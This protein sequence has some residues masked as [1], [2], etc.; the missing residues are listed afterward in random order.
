MEPEMQVRGG[1]SGGVP[2]AGGTRRVAALLACGLALAGCTASGSGG[3]PSSTE[4]ASPAARWVQAYHDALRQGPINVRP[5]YATDAVLDPTALGMSVA[6]GPED[7]VRAI[8]SAFPVVVDGAGNGRQWLYASADGLVESSDVLDAAESD[9]R[10][11][12]SVSHFGAD[13]VD[14][15]A[16]ALAELSW[17]DEHP[18]DPRI[19]AVHELAQ[20]YVAAWSSGSIDSA[21]A[22][23]APDAT[24]SDSLLGVRAAT[25]AD[26]AALA[27]AAPTAGGLPAI[28]LAQLP[29]YGGP[30]V[31]VLADTDPH[32]AQPMSAMVLLLDSTEAAACPGSLA[33]VAQLDE[34]GRIIEEARYHGLDDLRRCVPGAGPAEPSGSAGPAGSSASAVP[35]QPAAAA[36]P[37]WWDELTIPAPVA[38]EQTGTVRIGE[39]DVPVF[40]ATPGMADLVAWGAG[41]Y[42]A[43]GLPIP[44]VTEV[45]FYPPTVDLCQG[46]SGLA[47][48][49]SLSLCFD[50]RMSCASEDCRQWNPA[51]RKILLHE[52]G[53]A[54]MSDNLERSTIDR[55]TAQSGLP[56]WASSAQWEQ[57]AVELAASTLSWGLMDEPSAI[58]PRFGPRSCAELAALFRTLTGATAPAAATCADTE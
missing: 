57:R 25:A 40:N 47:A 13:G 15:Q 7:L 58:S 20:Q 43:A 11:L 9:P 50:R 23:Y 22:L 27:D 18:E 55:F 44:N 45:A 31:F 5:F 1:R 30:G 10:R 19:L 24:V 14:R 8:G 3:S 6:S 39:A 49:G 46:V 37:R 53:H 16:L 36:D 34:R 56:S 12:V 33:V 42:G 52:L 21:Q 28:T 38:K 32:H 17:R 4:V 41:R 2:S 48:G 26:A 51:V 35:G 54:W 29:D